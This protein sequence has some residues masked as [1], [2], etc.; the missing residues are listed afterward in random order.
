M[1]AC[2]R[3]LKGA[4][5]HFLTFDL[6]EVRD[7]DGQPDALGAIKQCIVR[8]DRQ[9]RHPIERGHEVGQ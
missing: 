1:P 2:G 4:L 8:R 5:R 9:I 7:R 6:L 3:D